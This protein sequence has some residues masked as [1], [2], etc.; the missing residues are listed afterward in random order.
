MSFFKLI[1][2]AIV[3]LVAGV[4]LG[5]T[6]YLN[7]YLHLNV[8]VFVPVGG[9]VLGALFGLIQ[10]GVARA[11]HA[12]IGFVGGLFL[13]VCGA[14]AYVA[15]DAGI[16][17]TDSIQND[18]AQ[19]VAVRDVIA[20]PDFV[21]MRLTRSSISARGHTIQLGET[22]TIVTFVVD[23]LGALLGTSALLFALALDAAYC[24]RCS[25][26]RKN[27]VK[28]ARDYP[29]DHAHATGL[30]QSLKHLA[31]SRQYAYLAAQV[32]ALPAV[33]QIS[34]RK[35]EAQESACPK[36]GRVAMHVSLHRPSKEGWTTTGERLVSEGGPADRASLVA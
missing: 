18:A 10:F 32:Q 16:W 19:S 33:S 20:L 36:C 7:E 1:L 29:L 17:L 15:T 14:L 2:A 12:K 4:A 27:L 3:S 21:A 35:L 25:R 6:P 23:E 26:Y 13:T 31:D 22:A 8:W 9:L 30:W 11:L 28:V 24:A 34:E 5:A